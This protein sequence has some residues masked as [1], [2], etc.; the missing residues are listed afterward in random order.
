MLLFPYALSLRLNRTRV[1]LKQ[2]VPSFACSAEACLNRTR[3]ELKLKMAEEIEADMFGLNRT[4]V[5][6]KREALA[7]QKQKEAEFES[8]QSGIETSS[9]AAS[10][11]LPLRV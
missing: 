10:S 9:L 6:L 5:E 7:R 4:R 1:E 11:R 8:N 3:V 2:G